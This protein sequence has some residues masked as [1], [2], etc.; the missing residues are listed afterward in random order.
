MSQ[1]RFAVIGSGAAGLQ[2]AAQLKQAGYSD[3]TLFEKTNDVGGVWQKNYAGF[4][5]QVRK[6]H[7]EIPGYPWPDSESDPKYP[8]G[9]E[10]QAYL[11]SY[12]RDA[13]VV[14]HVRFGVE[15][16]SLTPL[17]AAGAGTLPGSGGWEVEWSEVGASKASKSKV[18]RE[19]FDFVI[20]ATGLF[21]TPSR[22]SWAEPLVT[23]EPPAAGPW[24]VDAKDFTDESVAWGKHVVIVGAGKTAHDVGVTVSKVAASTTIV[25]RRGHWMAPQLV[26]GFLPFEFASYT[27]WSWALQPAYY[28]A[29]P[30]KKLL[31]T[32]F[33]PVKAL[34]WGLFGR[35]FRWQTHTPAALKPRHGLLT[36]VYDTIGMIDSKEL[37]RAFKSGRLVGHA[38]YVESVG[39]NSVKLSDGTEL[40]ADIVVLATGYE[41]ATARKLLPE[42]L[43]ASAGYQGDEQNVLPP[44][45]SNLAFIGLNATFQH[46]LTTALQS[47]W[48]VDTLK[49]DIKL[50]SKEEQL[51]DIARQQAW[52]KKFGGVKRNGNFVWAQHG[53]YHDA[54]VKD[55][56][57]RTAAYPR[58]NLLAEWFGYI[59]NQLYA[60]LFPGNATLRALSAANGKEKAQPQVRP[61]LTAK[62]TAAA[63][64]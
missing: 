17:T 27:R 28:A 16:R 6:W 2:V 3:V 54:L 42:S 57:G 40:Q 41:L 49:G 61:S 39:A 11:Q 36:G 50:P 55:I 56:R 35:I 1:Q 13:G 63:T 14:P 19:V 32:L 9:P 4:R 8:T 20:V 52:L 46:I 15:V 51:K 58:W 34:A 7:Y 53:K 26:L 10:T 23:E 31:H 38:G 29:G 44:E 60:P 30:V 12:A 33:R 64:A 47:R 22:P 18:H 21:N 25:A 45:L 43:L 5:L 48:L 24:V 59:Y 37:S 62:V